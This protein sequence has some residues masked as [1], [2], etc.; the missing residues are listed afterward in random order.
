[1][2]TA[3]DAP[4]A[5]S[6]QRMAPRHEV[7]GDHGSDLHH[8]SLSRCGEY[9]LFTAGQQQMMKAA[10]PLKVMMHLMRVF[11]E[12]GTKLPHIARFKTKAFHLSA[13]L[14]SIKSGVASSQAA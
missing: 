13:S 8:L 10:P 6:V 1:M 7:R 4:P 3:V 12:A 14:L 2:M 11:V 9:L 5:S